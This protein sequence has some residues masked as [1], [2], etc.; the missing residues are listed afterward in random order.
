M[1][2][3]LILFFLL[4]LL[5]ACNKETP[6]IETEEI[7]ELT[8]LYTKEKRDWIQDVTY[9]FNEQGV[10][11]STGKTIVINPIEISVDKAYNIIKEGV[12]KPH[13]FSS[14]SQFFIAY[15]NQDWQQRTG[16]KL[17]INTKSIL[18]S[19]VV[20]AMWKPMAE[21]LGW[22]DKAISWQDIAR[23]TQMG[24]PW[25]QYRSLPSH[26]GKFYFAH[27]N[28][29]YDESAMLSILSMINADNNY[30]LFKKMQD[31]VTH[32]GS[33]NQVFVDKMYTGKPEYLSAIATYEHL[34]IGVNQKG[35][36]TM[37]FPLVAIYPKEGTYIAN[38]PIGVI[39]RDWVTE[40]HKE[41]INIYI[42]YLFSPIVQKKA[43]QYG[44]RP[45]VDTEIGAPLTESLGIL[46]DQPKKILDYE[47]ILNYKDLS[48]FWQVNKKSSH[49]VLLIDTNMDKQ[50]LYRLQ[51]SM[52]LFL[53]SLQAQ[54]KVSIATFNTK[55]AW[56]AKNMNLTHENRK[57]LSNIIYSIQNT[58]E[59]SAVQDALL[60]VK[61]NISTYNTISAV[62]L[63]STQEDNASRFDLAS[64]IDKIRLTDNSYLS[65]FPI[66]YGEKADTKMLQQFVNFTHTKLYK[67][68]FETLLSVFQELV[69]YF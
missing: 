20:I 38:H 67:A 63:F 48:A 10:T 42:N 21:A 50:T 37:P 68:D 43:V 49:V 36:Y 16:K 52:V 56:L 69:L 12:D 5:S 17:I 62:I 60:Q 31:S 9:D 24:K 6:E 8:F 26:W 14:D 51:A 57:T 32:Y 25:R 65:I 45:V 33:N 39:N 66:A 11:T 22:P 58:E 13:I 64:T 44:F 19:P 18:H 1:Y 55:L 27:S 23:L 4:F 35:G 15:M 28:P 29:L 34:V 7:L 46:I 3:F 40:E 59:K 54:D 61:A 41:A 2:K 47:N 30:I 53:N